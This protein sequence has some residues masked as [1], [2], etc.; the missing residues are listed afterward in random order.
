MW[1]IKFFT[2]CCLT[3]LRPMKCLLFI[4]AVC[5]DDMEVLRGMSICILYLLAAL[6]KSNSLHAISCMLRK[7]GS[8]ETENCV[9]K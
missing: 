9:L 8:M 3:S 4:A 1:I 5:S 6:E 7:C 2:T